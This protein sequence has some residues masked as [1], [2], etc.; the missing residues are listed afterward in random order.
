MLNKQEL[1]Q[2]IDN[3]IEDRSTR[4]EGVVE[5]EEI[6]GLQEIRK[7][8]ESE[9]VLQYDQYSWLCDLVDAYTEQKVY[10]SVNDVF[11]P[12]EEQK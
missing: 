4:D 9:G 11:E 2:V 5:P 7:V 1:L 3:E 10:D 12:N 6:E 8:I